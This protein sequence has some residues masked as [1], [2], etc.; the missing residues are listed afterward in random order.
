M[1]HS[2]MATNRQFRTPLDRP[3]SAIAT[4]IGGGKKSIELERFLR[5]AV[6]GVTGAI[7]DLGV[8][9]ILQATILPP[10]FIT[11]TPLDFNLD[12]LPFNF[13]ITAVPLS[14]NVALA[15]TLAFIAAVLSNFTWT[16]LWVYPESRANIRRKLG[17][18]ALISVT[19]WLARTLW[20]TLMYVPIGVLV[21]PIV[22]PLI[23]IIQED[24]IAN[25]VTEKRFGSITAQLVAMGFVMLWN[26]FANRYWTYSD[27]D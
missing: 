27:V 18:F 10:A 25:P 22:E 2:T 19:G 24:F 3:I 26:F 23:Q 16:T 6:V 20:I 7:I 17:Q 4:R 12:T 1:S 8:L 9:T 14:F 13:E 5:F 21:T 15:T 11:P